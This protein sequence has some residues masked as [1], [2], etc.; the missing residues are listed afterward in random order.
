MEKVKDSV[1]A[2]EV[3]KLQDQL[4]IFQEKVKDSEQLAKSQ[5]NALFGCEKEKTKVEEELKEKHKENEALQVRLKEIEVKVEQLKRT[6]LEVT[7]EKVVVEQKNV[8]LIE[9]LNQLNEEMK[10]RGERIDKLEQVTLDQ[11]VKIRDLEKIR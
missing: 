9:E 7:D 10:K 5:E 2:D 8:G 1:A 6:V 3:T 4:T 11:E